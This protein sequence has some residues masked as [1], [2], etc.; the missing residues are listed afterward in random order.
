MFFVRPLH[1]RDRHFTRPTANLTEVTIDLCSGRT[2]Q[3]NTYHNI[4]IYVCICIY[5]NY[6]THSVRVRGNVL[7][8]FTRA[9]CVNNNSLFLIHY[10]DRE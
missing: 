6:R 3:T 7:L 1:E 4:C 10:S 5:S 2:S 8:S 9:E